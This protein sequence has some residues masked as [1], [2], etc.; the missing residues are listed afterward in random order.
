MDRR[1]F[2]KQYTNPPHPAAFSGLSNLSHVYPKQSRARLRKLLESV[3]A[4]SKHKEVRRSAQKNPFIVRSRLAVLQID[5]LDV[6]QLASHNNDVKY[7]FMI[8]DTFSRRAWGI[9]LQNK[10]ADSTR[11]VFYQFLHNVLSRKDRS[12][13]ER[14]LSDRGREFNNAKFKKLLKE[15][16]IALTHPNLHAPHVERLNRTIQK[17]MYGYMT[18]KKTKRYIEHLQAIF[19][20]YNGRIHSSHGL[21]PNS[22]F[23]RKNEKKVKYILA[24]KRQHREEE[25]HSPSLKVGDFVRIEKPRKAFSRSYKETHSK[26][27]FIVR[28]IIR[29]LPQPMYEV[30][31]LKGKIINSRLYAHQLA[32]I[33]PNNSMFAIEK[34]IRR[35]GRGRKKEVLVKWEGYSDAFNTW[36]KASEAKTFKS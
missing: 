32:K 13:V 6:R 28:R 35:R 30:E 9:P 25:R 24:Y 26:E 23:L 8:I 31:D 12:S 5:L 2:I 20:S 29:N 1:K 18:E 15:E 11:E 19:K 17:I 10:R 16:N 7:I 21:T 34:I 4:Y 14:V 27:M 33:S 3:D 22:A 36:I